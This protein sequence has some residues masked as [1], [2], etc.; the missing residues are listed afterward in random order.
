VVAVAVVGC[1]FFEN[2]QDGGADAAVVSDAAVDEG[3]FVT[4][5]TVGTPCSLD[6]DC[7]TLLGPTATCLQG[8]S[9]VGDVLFYFP[10]GYCSLACGAGTC[11]EG[12]TCL[13]AGGPSYGFCHANCQSSRHC[14]APVYCCVQSASSGEKLC[15]APADPLTYCG[16]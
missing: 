10:D 12:S 9:Q 4:S 7:Q 11:P 1:S 14:R 3:D 16:Y 15:A 5:Q 2:H 8:S 13:T 6:S